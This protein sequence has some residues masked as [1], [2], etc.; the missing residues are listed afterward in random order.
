M[1]VKHMTEEAYLEKVQRE[2]L[3]SKKWRRF[4]KSYNGNGFKAKPIKYLPIR[5]AFYIPGDY[6]RQH[7][8]MQY[9]ENEILVSDFLYSAMSA[10]M[11]RFFLTHEL[12]HHFLR[13]NDQKF[14]DGSC[15]F[16]DACRSLGID[17]EVQLCLRYR[18][19]SDGKGGWRYR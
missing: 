5:F 19:A 17:L 16:N 15:A 10:R 6:D 11:I 3:R 18:K 14:T 1:S 13:V 8:V 12:V 7:A 9:R 2:I 4:V